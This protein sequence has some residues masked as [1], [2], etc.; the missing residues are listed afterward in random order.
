MVTHRR[1]GHLV[2]QEVGHVYTLTQLLA[3]QQTLRKAP[4]PLVTPVVPL[5]ACWLNRTEMSCYFSHLSAVMDR[6]E[7]DESLIPGFPPLTTVG[8]LDIC[9]GYFSHLSAET[10]RGEFD[11]S[12]IPGF[13]PFLGEGTVDICC[14]QP[15]RMGRDA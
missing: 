1:V 6:G 4:K 5:K 14:E 8:T 12:L 15:S 9:C 10:D 7:F 3:D 2:V 11:E 13:P